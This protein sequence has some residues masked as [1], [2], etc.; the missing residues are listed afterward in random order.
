MSI[1]FTIKQA[2]DTELNP[3]IIPF[4]VKNSAGPKVEKLGF[5]TLTK[6]SIGH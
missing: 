6:T 4:I 5:I 3:E 2:P 1:L